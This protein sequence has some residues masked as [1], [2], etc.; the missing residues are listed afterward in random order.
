MKRAM[1]GFPGFAAMSPTVVIKQ[2][3]A[4]AAANNDNNNKAGTAT[5]ATAA[6]ASCQ[7]SRLASAGVPVSMGQ[8]Q[9]AGV[10]VVYG[11]DGEESGY[12]DVSLGL[13][14][15]GSSAVSLSPSSS[16]TDAVLAATSKAAS[17]GNGA[18][19]E[20]HGQH[21]TSL[22]DC[23]GDAI[24]RRVGLFADLSHLVASW[25]EEGQQEG[26]QQQGQQQ[27]QQRQQW[28]A[29][30]SVA[31]PAGALQT[32]PPTVVMASSVDHMVSAA[33]TDGAGREAAELGGRLGWVQG[34]K[35]AG[36]A[37]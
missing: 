33:R 14:S 15:T 12:T 13:P 22:L 29:H 25:L 31:L 5:T 34:R 26:Q 37:G 32:L 2:T 27:G 7:G 1:N 23:V 9:R 19:V 36:R 21:W 18:V 30:S 4:A 20:H 8:E 28:G 24:P 17:R 3:L 11:E 6:G 16:A 35:T 10:A